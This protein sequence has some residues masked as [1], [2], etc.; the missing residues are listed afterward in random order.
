MTTAT[1]DADPA[2]NLPGVKAPAVRAAGLTRIAAAFVAAAAL[3]GAGCGSGPVLHPAGGTVTLPDGQPAAGCIV[4]FAS[5]APATPGLNARG[6]VR[7]DGTF[8]LATRIGSDDQ[9]GAVAGPHR[10]VVIAPALAGSGVPGAVNAVLVP[11]RYSDYG[12][13]KL[14]FEVAPGPNSF[15]IKLEK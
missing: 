1:P 3:G 10:A 4:E 5:D 12:T 11:E 14:T 7:P 8:T 6:V 2:E 9:P 13:A 15:A